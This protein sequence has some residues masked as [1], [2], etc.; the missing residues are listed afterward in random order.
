MYLWR[1]FAR[2]FDARRR[3]VALSLGLAIGQALAL[4]P[5]GLL[6]RRAFDT[7]IPNGDR[8]ELVLLGSAVVALFA[9]SSGLLLLGRSVML[10]ITKGAVARLR[11]DLLAR[12]QTLPRSWLDS[13]DVGRLHSTIV[14]DS[15]RVELMTEAVLGLI[16]PASIVSAVLLASLAVIDVGLLLVLLAVLPVLLVT[17]RWLQHK[18]RSLVHGQQRDFD[19]F[20]A[21]ILSNLR[22]DVTIRAQNAEGAELQGG[23]PTSRG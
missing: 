13:A 1:S 18:A 7:A 15:D 16:V 10:R 20:S 3:L 22:A 19:T 23:A 12:I 9:I 17:G 2:L 6:V 11:V 8:T 14:Q 4:V 5:I 21:R